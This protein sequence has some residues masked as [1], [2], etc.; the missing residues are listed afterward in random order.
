MTRLACA[1]S[2][3]LAAVLA[4]GCATHRPATAGAD[5]PS[6]TYEAD[7]AVLDVEFSAAGGGSAVLEV[8]LPRLDM[9]LQP[10]EWMNGTPTARGASAALRQSDRGAVVAVT[11]SGNAS[12]AVQL[13]T[14]GRQTCA[15]FRT[16]P[17]ST[18]PD[19]GNG[20]VEVY[21][22]PGAGPVGHASVLVRWI[23]NGCGE[24]TL[25]DGVPEPGIW[26]ALAGRTIPAGCSG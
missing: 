15:E 23:R 19:P 7:S 3:L 1:A 11:G 26:T 5:A 13:A 22:D 20:T 12:W 6:P 16:D 10:Q 24:A 4:A 2:L 17:W 8:P 25:Y 21:L 14:Q 18:D 9:C